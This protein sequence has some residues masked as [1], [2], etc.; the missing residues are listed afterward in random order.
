MNAL[1]SFTLWGILA[2]AGIAVPILIHLLYRKHRRQVE[3]A[4]MELLNRALVTRSGQLKLEDLL[5]LLLRCLAILLIAA[6]LLRPVLTGNTSWVGEKRV[7]VVI[8]V[9]GSY[10]MGHRALAESR[11][12]DAMKR[13]KEILGTVS[14]EDP[15]T[16]VQI[17]DR[18]VIHF[19]STGYNP[20]KFDEVLET[21]E[22]S[23]LGLS[24]DK[25]FEQL[26]ELVAELK[27]PVK[28]CYIVTDAQ[29]G[30]WS[31]L[32]QG[33][34]EILTR[35]T[36]DAA[37]YIVPTRKPQEENI[38]L[39][40]LSFASGSLTEEGI[41]RFTAEV[42]NEGLSRT[43]G[44]EATF[45]LGGRKV[46]KRAL[47]PLNPG[48]S[49]NLSFFAS[50]AE[51]GEVPL[52][53]RI[54]G[55]S[56]GLKV[57][58]IRHAVVNVRSAIQV[59][60][61]DNV[62]DI[63][64]DTKFDGSFFLINAL[65]LKGGSDDRINVTR[66]YWQDMPRSG[67]DDFDVIILANV[68][69]VDLELASR[70]KR[71]VENGG[72][73]M[74]FMGDDVDSESYNKRLAEGDSDLLPAKLLDAAHVLENARPWSISV[75]R[76]SNPLAELVQRLPE[77]IVATAQVRGV[78]KTE[79][80]AEGEA[81]MTVPALK[82]ALLSRRTVGQGTVL[83]FATTADRAWSNLA[84]HP[85]YLMLLREAV[86]NITSDPESRMVLIG[87]TEIIPMPGRKI[88]ETLDITAPD[89]EVVKIQVTQSDG[90]PAIAFTA[91]DAGKY[92]IPGSDHAADITLAANVDPSESAVRVVDPG[93]IRSTVKGTKTVIVDGAANFTK[94]ITEGRQGA[95]IGNW[96]LYAGILLFIMQ[97]VLARRFS[98]RMAGK[99]EDV[100]GSL[101]MG[102]VRSAR[103]S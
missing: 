68:P 37:V 67:L 81:I 72:G 99:E 1:N 96:L 16:I 13:V 78:M 55:L 31:T 21:L 88:G 65:R 41:A 70:L 59:L 17:S 61:V 100:S 85:I 7:G 84:V 54:S 45:F 64:E 3:W 82:T 14:L 34:R 76:S 66:T 69:E 79:P 101:Q 32:S 19:R 11:H 46:S 30:D 71:Y 73:L 25:N 92:Q 35:L 2:V 38:S 58:N 56:D 22:P 28:E 98:E 43:T 50:F 8:A 15:V 42:R 94:M 44:G 90:K 74:F 89:G 95:E 4:A 20:E 36:E 103:R 97:S 53:T 33:S 23:S 5:I 48:Q 62:R 77:E 39:R 57:D 75:A 10:S 102:R 83:L 63:N 52:T 18:P 40:R 47:G 87:Q 29:E 51:A 49:R 86:V 9:D 93:V 80:R 12:D 26:E 91:E 6:A 60:C 24:L 27:A